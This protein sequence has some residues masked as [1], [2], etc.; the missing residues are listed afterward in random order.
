MSLAAGLR[1]GAYEVLSLIG[2]GGM[3]EVYRARDVRLGREVAVKALPT[4]LAHDPIRLQRFEHE[5][6]AAAALNH[7]NILAV[8][9]SGR[10]CRAQSV[11]GA[12]S[13][14]S[15]SRSPRLITYV[16]LVETAASISP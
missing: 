11:S 3:G 5:A 7:P 8:F 14:R 1:L 4:E 15:F 12:R 9:D 10:F 2:A 6:C 13:R 16:H